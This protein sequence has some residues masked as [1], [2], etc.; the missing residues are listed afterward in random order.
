MT[1]ESDDRPEDRGFGE[2]PAPT[3]GAARRVAQ[4]DRQVN[5]P[6]TASGR[7]RD[8]ADA[9]RPPLP[10]TE[11]DEQPFLRN[12]YVLAGIAVAGAIVLAV[13]VV[14]IFGGSG[15]GSSSGGGNNGVLVAPLTPGA[16]R[17]VPARSI[18]SASVREGPG[19][20]SNPVAELLRGQ[21]VEVIG[22]NADASWIAIY[23][24]PGSQL[25]GWVPKTALSLSSD[26]T[27]LPV[28]AVTPVPRPTVPT[29]TPPPEPTQTATGTATPTG[30]PAPAG[31]PDLAAS[32]VPAS[33][34]MGQRLIV[35]VRNNGPAALTSRSI[36]VLIQTAQ[37]NQV[38]LQSSPVTTLQ[39][40][41]SIDIDTNYI[42]NQ[43]VIVVVD[44][45]QALGDPNIS[46]NRVDCAL[47]TQPTPLPI[48]TPPLFRTA[49]P[50]PPIT[51]P[52]H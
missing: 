17:G 23:Y 18:A 47:V 39:P 9:R 10:P 45:L 32:V 48:G 37:G 5:R 1:S 20:E 28:I 4:F 29:S 42:V 44:P 30:T 40:G 11:Q 3:D 13:L 7:G 16:T 50:V 22:R 26:A 34:Q 12:P 6:P 38:A 19:L 33:C 15:G 21:D 36:T 31:G 35:N 27:L 49:T 24:P 14:V 25:Q 52:P 46:N 43:R 51:V 2:P 8:S 41:E